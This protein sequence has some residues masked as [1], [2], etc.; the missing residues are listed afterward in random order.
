MWQWDGRVA[1]AGAPSAA[2]ARL[3]LRARLR[4][5]A[6]LLEAA[7]S[8]AAACENGAAAAE[9]AA[10]AAAGFEADARV[11][12]GAA[13]AGLADHRKQLA[14]LMGRSRERRSQARLARPRPGPRGGRSAR[15]RS[16]LVRSRRGACW[17]CPIAPPPKPSLPTPPHRRT[18]RARRWPLPASPATTPVPALPEAGATL[19]A[20]EAAS[21]RSESQVAAL[22]P[23]RDRV[24]AERDEAQAVLAACDAACVA[25]GDLASWQAASDEAAAAERQAA[26]ALELARSQSDTASRALAEAQAR[27]ASLDRAHAQSEMDA[28]SAGQI[29]DGAEAALARETAA[30]ETLLAARATLPDAIALTEQAA[31]ARQI[32]ADTRSRAAALAEAAATLSAAYAEASARLPAVQT[33]LA[34]W[35]ARH[36]EAARRRQALSA[37]GQAAQTDCDALAEAPRHPFRQGCR[38]R[39]S[40]GSG[41]SQPQR[42]RRRVARAAD[43]RL[44]AAAR[45]QRDAEAAQSACRET[46]ARGEGGADAAPRGAPRRPGTRRRTAWSGSPNCRK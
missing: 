12:L 35:R 20:L 29:F 9:A 42:G 19:R 2:A 3:G 30:H 18:W 46:V 27:M 4:E 45:A 34:A 41:R 23:Q 15:R 10:A 32:L 40:A 6:L 17:P 5:L 11:A 43:D 44:R 16:C 38:F 8:E 39:H 28:A 13:E 7:Q 25:L 37:R 14:A 33:E 21:S 36:D 26:T 31:A 24:L 1:R 22:L